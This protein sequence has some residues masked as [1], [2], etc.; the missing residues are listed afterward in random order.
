MAHNYLKKLGRLIG[1]KAIAPIGITHV[2]VAHD[3]WCA[4]LRGEGDCNCDPE[5]R[6]ITL[7]A[8]SPDGKNRD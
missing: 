6:E 3:S 1:K 4:A 5:I 2:E 7:R 8:L